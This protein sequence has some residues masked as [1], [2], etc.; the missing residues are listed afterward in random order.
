M[1]SITSDNLNCIIEP[2]NEIGA[3]VI[4]IVTNVDSVDFEYY[5]VCNKHY[6]KFMGRY[7]DNANS[8]DNEVYHKEKSKFG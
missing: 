8:S 2:C 5:R 4:S 6:D 3:Q 7:Y 1:T